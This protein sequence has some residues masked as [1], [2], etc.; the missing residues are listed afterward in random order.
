MLGTPRQAWPKLLGK[1]W[2]RLLL[3]IAHLCQPK[4]PAGFTS[5]Q[6]QRANSCSKPSGNCARD[7][8]YQID[9]MSETSDANITPDQWE[10]REPRMRA[11]TRR[12]VRHHRAAIQRVA[13]ALLVRETLSAEDIDAIC[14]PPVHARRAFLATHRN[15]GTTRRLLWQ[16]RRNW[17]TGS[18]VR[19]RTESCPGG[20]LCFRPTC[21]PERYRAN[22]EYTPRWPRVQPFSALSGPARLSRHMQEC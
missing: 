6:T 5:P 18:R 1:S 12:L 20:F 11:T 4:A 9:W 3:R 17:E 2:V 22:S 19:S 21:A 13:A 14:S 15:R 7:D 8:R 16:Q 10:R